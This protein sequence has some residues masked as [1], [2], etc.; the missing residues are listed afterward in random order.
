MKAL[1][2]LAITTI[3][4]VP[5]CTP[6]FTNWFL[7]KPDP[8]IAT[9]YEPPPEYVEWWA[10]AES[11]T[12][13]HKNLHH[14]KWYAVKWPHLDGQRGWDPGLSTER[15]E[16]YVR[17]NRTLDRTEVLSQMASM[18][19]PYVG[20]GRFDTEFF[21]RT[22]TCMGLSNADWGSPWR[23]DLSVER[24]AV[25]TLSDPD[26]ERVQLQ[27]PVNATVEALVAL[28]RPAIL[29]ADA[30]AEP[31][32]VTVYQVEARLL[33]LFT[34]ADHDYYL[35]LASPQDTTITMIA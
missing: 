6:P 26:R 33:S 5:G 15:N 24:W 12:H 35:V 32:E 4:L 30:R 20:W 28:Q 29:L 14:W 1:T 27:T 2:K 9:P 3:M 31:V 22:L 11:C 17:D 10:V 34:E 16:V 19:T 8:Q 21:Q 25:K 23:P 13:R 7:P 18:L